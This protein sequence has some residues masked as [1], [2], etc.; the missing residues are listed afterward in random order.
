VGQ[1]PFDLDAC[2]DRLRLVT[3]QTNNAAGDGEY[4]DG[5]ADVF[6]NTCRANDDIFTQLGDSGEASITAALDF[7]G[8]RSCTAISGT[9]R[10][11]QSAEGR[12]ILQPTR[13][14]AVQHRIPGLF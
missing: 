9:L 14:N 10:T 1:S 6:P 8:G 11:A 2:D 12:E 3:F 4:Y 13:P 7:L 5:L